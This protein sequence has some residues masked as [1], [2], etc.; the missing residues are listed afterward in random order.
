MFLCGG[1]INKP[2]IEYLTEK[3]MERRKVYIKEFKETAIDMYKNSDRTLLEISEELG[4][5][6]SNLGRWIREKE[7]AEQGNFTAF[8]GLGK[9]RDDKNVRLKKEKANLR[10]IK[11]IIKKGRGILNSKSTPAEVFEVMK[12]NKDIHSI[13]KMS[14]EFRVSRSGFYAWLNRQQ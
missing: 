11:E 12:N 13:A 10:E 7:Q 14:K 5:D 4:C 8:P 3:T 2:V 9:P 6:R 1:Q